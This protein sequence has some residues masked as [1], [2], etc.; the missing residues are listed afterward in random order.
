MQQKQA[1]MCISRIHNKEISQFE[2]GIAG[3][4]VSIIIQHTSE[5]H[6]M[7]HYKVMKTSD[8][9]LWEQEVENEYSMMIKGNVWKVV[10][11]KAKRS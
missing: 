8:A 4:G 2:I 11:K 7:I 1:I 3:A 9:K 10:K 6:V 5:L